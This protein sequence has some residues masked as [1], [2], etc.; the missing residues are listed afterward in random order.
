MRARVAFLVSG[1]D[2]GYYAPRAELEL[3][4]ATLDA[5]RTAAAVVDALLE[6]RPPTSQMFD[7]MGVTA[8]RVTP[9][10]VALREGDAPA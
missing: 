4:G 7:V 1:K 2:R 3:A 8:L 10:L 6:G 5:A 9:A